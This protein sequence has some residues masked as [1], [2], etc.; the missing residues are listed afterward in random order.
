MYFYTY[1]IT[2]LK[3][4]KYYYGAHSTNNL[5]DGY[6]GSGRQLELA[7]KK[8]GKEYFTIEILQHF[9][10]KEEMYNAEAGLITEHVVSDPQSYNEKLGGYGGWDHIDSSGNN[11]PMRNELI[12]RKVV[13]TT[14][15]NGSYYTEKRILAQKRATQAAAA[16]NL[17]K[18]RPE[19]S[20]FMKDW[21]TNYWKENREHIRDKLSSTYV[22]ISPTGVEYTTNRLGEFCK[23][24]NLPFVTM[25]NLSNS[26]STAKRGK[27]KNW[28]IKKVNYD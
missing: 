4:G 10:S 5:N 13:E 18:K 2:N 8:Y 28:F 27:C 19:H 6:M 25:W 9:S 24:F 15:A 14:R 23:E 3:N 21:A 22:I 26:G 20:S 11:N 17:G 16:S 7:K 12:K 1:K